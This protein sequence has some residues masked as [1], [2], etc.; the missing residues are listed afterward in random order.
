MRPDGAA[1]RLARVAGAIGV[2]VSPH[3]LRHF[4]VTHWLSIG[5]SIPDIA[6]MI[7]DNPKTVMQTYAHHIP[8]NRRDM[9]RRLAQLIREA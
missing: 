8:S 9:V 1:K 7:G 5:V 4:A 6:A 2:D 3:D